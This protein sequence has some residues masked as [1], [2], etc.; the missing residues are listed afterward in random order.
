MISSKTPNELYR[1]GSQKRTTFYSLP[2][3]TISNSIEL[4]GKLAN[5]KNTIHPTSKEINQFSRVKNI[6]P[7]DSDILS[8]SHSNSKENSNLIKFNT[9]S[10]ANLRKIKSPENDNIIN[11]TE[12]RIA[13]LAYKEPLKLKVKNKNNDTFRSSFSFNWNESIAKTKEEKPNIRKTEFSKYTHSSQIHLLPGK[14]KRKSSEIRD[15]YNHN[16][17]TNNKDAL[18]S[19]Y[20]NLKNY[21]SNNF[22]KEFYK[23]I[24]KSLNKED[25]L[26]NCHYSQIFKPLNIINGKKD[27]KNEANNYKDSHITVINNKDI[28][29]SLDKDAN[30]IKKNINNH[31]KSSY[32]TI[33]T[34]NNTNSARID[35][36]DTVNHK[37]SNSYLQKF[38]TN[39][40]SKAK[41][42]TNSNNNTISNDILN[43]LSNNKAIEEKSINYNIDNNIRFSSNSRLKTNKSKCSFEITEKI[44]HP[45]FSSTIAYTNNTIEVNTNNT[46]STNCPI[47]REMSNLMKSPDK[48]LIFK[49]YVNSYCK[50]KLTNK[51]N[52]KKHFDSD[53]FQSNILLTMTK[54]LKD[55]NNKE[56]VKIEN[57]QKVNYSVGNNTGKTI[58]NKCYAPDKEVKNVVD[59]IYNPQQQV[60]SHKKNNSLVSSRIFGSAKNLISN[61]S[62]NNR[63]NNNHSSGVNSKRKIGAFGMNES[64]F[65]NHKRNNSHINT[66]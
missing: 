20:S 46:D 5:Y 57:N 2:K 14:E 32:N 54:H 33:N 10:F 29:D 56:I 30:M 34:T 65:N 61:A 4:Q 12:T 18:N 9:Q 1:C 40:N 60:C 42:I 38:F 64:S 36:I 51:N 7:R 21:D 27:M 28:K 23:F 25:N 62:N 17:I 3:S 19:A 53:F 52:N 13:Y 55:A 63:V 44:G 31:Y 8:C 49:N 47:N 39:T 15:D 48:S 16:S 66:K 41:P 35:N 43:D 58:Y 45:T 59:S 50:K 26:K 37:K 22:N 11:H 24:K 6:K